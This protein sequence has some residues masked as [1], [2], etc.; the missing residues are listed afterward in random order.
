[1]RPD[2]FSGGPEGRATSRRRRGFAL[3]VVV[4][5]VAIAAT[6]GYATLANTATQAVVGQS[7]AAIARAEAVAESGLN[8][9]LY[10]LQYPTNAPAFTGTFWPGAANVAVGP[11]AFTV[12]VTDAGN[13]VYTVVSAAAVAMGDGTV[14]AR[15]VTATVQVK[16]GFGTPNQAAGCNGTLSPFAGRLTVAGDLHAGGPVA[17]GGTSVVSGTVFA[18]ALTTQGPPPGG[19]TAQPAGTASAPTVVKDYSTYAVGTA[20]Y[21]ATLLPVDPPAGSTL[22]PTPLNPAGVYL[23]TGRTAALRGVTLSGTLVV[24][25]G[26]LLVTGGTV[27]AVAAALPQFPAVVVDGAIT[28]DGGNE[29]LTISGLTWA[30]GGIA[31]AGASSASSNVTVVGGLLVTAPV[32]V[33]PAY[34]GGLTVAYD[35]ALSDVPDFSTQLQVPKSVRVLSWS[36]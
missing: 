33:D 27:N 22:G 36:P 8:Y 24:R 25:N 4:A 30:A 35:A 32:A 1:M 13:G 16:T 17:L 28:V 26:G 5:A 6:L 2:L 18:P 34:D 12:T 23:V 7:A 20:T 29:L 14:I 10:N 9:A 31:H 15:Q 21:S 3:M 11:D 19:Y